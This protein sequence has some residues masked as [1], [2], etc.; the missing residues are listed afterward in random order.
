MFRDPTLVGCWSTFAAH[1]DA[2][3]VIGAWS[4]REPEL[5]G[6]TDVEALLAAWDHPVRTHDVGAVLVRLAAVDGAA[7]DDALILLLHLLS[8]VVWRLVGQ[9]A[10]LSDDITALVLGE[11]TCRIRTYPWRTRRAALVTT[12]EKET[13]RAVLAD[14]RPSNRYH[15]DR[16]ERL[17]LDGDL[18]AVSG[19]AAAVSAEA[20]DLDLV[21]LLEW[22]AAAG[23]ARDDLRLLVESERARDHRGGRADE[24]V[25]GRYRICRRTV[26]RRRARTLAALRA[27]APEYLAAVA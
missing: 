10:D 5:A 21:D 24:A 19:T 11:L 20:D 1:L 17:T 16:V 6:I 12:L 22:A 9:L 7:D 15:P 3:V 14:L 23:V 13:R 4:C 18:P 8:G 2:D 26:L 27:L 25:A